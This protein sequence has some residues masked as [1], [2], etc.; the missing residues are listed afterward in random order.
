M[1]RP[2]KWRRVCKL[3]DIK[4]YGPVNIDDVNDK[5][6][7]IMTVEELETI[8]LIDLEEMNQIDCAELMGVARSTVQRIYNDARRKIAKSIIAG[9]VLKVK[10][11]NYKV[12]STDVGME[13]CNNCFRK[14]HRHGRK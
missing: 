10:G 11:G 14:R 1:P 5:D 9:K 2:K 13:M 3:P 4:A 6:A 12:C 7:V 8:R